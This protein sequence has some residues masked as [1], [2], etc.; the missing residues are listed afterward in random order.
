MTDNNQGPEPT[1]APEAATT[2]ISQRVQSACDIAAGRAEA[3]QAAT[4]AAIVGAKKDLN[5]K[6]RGPEWYRMV[7]R[8]GWQYVSDERL[9]SGRFLAADRRASVH[10]DV[11]SGE[12]VVGHDRGSPVDVA[13]LVASPN[14]EGKVL[15]PCEFV[16]RR[17]GQLGVTLPDGSLVVLPDPRKR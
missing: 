10:G 5:S 17:D 8:G 16:R 9:P 12:I 7:Y 11:Y 13:R 1:T 14:A 15:V 3:D 4:G 6:G 2:T